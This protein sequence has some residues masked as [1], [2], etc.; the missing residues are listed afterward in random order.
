MLGIV[1]ILAVL[2]LHCFTH[3]NVHRSIFSYH[4]CEDIDVHLTYVTATCSD[5]L[6]QIDFLNSFVEIAD[7]VATPLYFIFIFLV[8]KFLWFND[9]KK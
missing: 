9:G 1:F 3:E 4:E 8:L 2:F 7:M 5:D 6:K